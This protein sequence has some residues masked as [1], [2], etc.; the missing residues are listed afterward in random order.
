MTS[1]AIVFRKDKLNARKEA[2]I[3][4]RIIKNRKVSYIASGIMLPPNQ[5]NEKKSRVKL[6]HPSSARLNSYLSNKFTEIQ[7]TVLHHETLSKS[8]TSKTLREKV[9]GK[10]PSDF[11]GFADAIVEQYIKEGRIG[12]GDKNRSVVAKLRD[13]RNS[14]TFQDI[15][16]EFLIKYEQHLREHHNN[17][18]NT[19]SKDMKFLRKVFNDAIRSDVIGLEAN[20]F[21][22][23]QI[24]QE[25][26]HRDYLTEEELLR[27]RDCDIAAGNKLAL[28]RD[29]F[30][31]AAYTGGLRISDVLQLRWS[32]FDGSHLHVVITKTGTQVSI[33]V[34][35]KGLELMCRYRRTE[36]CNTD[37]I[38]PF[39]STNLDTANPFVLDAAIATATTQVNRNLK[40]LA[41]LAG[42]TKRLSFH[43]SRHSFAVLALRK[44]ISIDKVSKLM[45]HAAI[46]E[47]QVYAKI[48]NEELDKAMEVFND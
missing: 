33:K 18:T 46:R 3:H 39:F 11:F 36:K 41:K 29:M 40:K 4:F 32:N 31:F 22:K 24:K 42:I 17:C 48:V 38:F 5:W 44:G 43:I 25:R 16:P 47:T 8:L 10:R 14:L 23:Y 37:F 34:P 28:C 1:V 45:A 20:P 21:R 15:T 19:V 9:F 27:V 35:N 30:I 12:T 26:T 6:T 13:Y 2:P 7:D